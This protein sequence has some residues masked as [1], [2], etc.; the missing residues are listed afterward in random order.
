M[1]SNE[2][3]SPGSRTNQTSFGLLDDQA[4]QDLSLE[5]LNKIRDKPPIPL[6][7]IN[8]RILQER[9]FN[10]DKSLNFNPNENPDQTQ[11]SVH[12]NESDL[13][14]LEYD[15]TLDVDDDDDDED[16]ENLKKNDFKDMSR[17]FAHSFTKADFTNVSPDNMDKSVNKTLSNKSSDK[18]NNDLLLQ[19]CGRTPWPTRPTRPNT[20]A[21]MAEHLG[22]LGRTPWPTRPNTLADMAEYPGRLGRPHR[23][24]L[25]A[26]PGRQNGRGRAGRPSGVTILLE[27]LYINESSGILRNSGDFENFK[28]DNSNESRRINYDRMD[29][30]NSRT[31]NN[32][33]NFS[34]DKD[35]SKDREINLI[36]DTLDQY[37]KKL[38]SE[39]DTSLSNDL[40]NKLS[41]SFNLTGI[42]DTTACLKQMS[43]PKEDNHE[44]KNDSTLNFSSSLSD[45]MEQLIQQ[46]VERV[47]R[48]GQAHLLNNYNEDYLNLISKPN[49]EI[50]YSTST[51]GPDP[52]NASFNFT[53]DIP[54]TP[55]KTFNQTLE[56]QEE[57]KIIEEV[58]SKKTPN[59][60]DDSIQNSEEAVPVSS[61]NPFDNPFDS[62]LGN[63]GLNKNQEPSFS[64]FKQA[65]DFLDQLN[66]DEQLNRKEF[67]DNELTLINQTSDN[68]SDDS[69][70]SKWWKKPAQVQPNN[71]EV[72]NMSNES[73]KK[74]VK[75]EEFFMGKSEMPSYLADKNSDVLLSDVSRI[76]KNTNVEQKDQQEPTTPQNYDDITFSHNQG[77]TLSSSNFSFTLN[78]SDTG[79]FILPKNTTN[80]KSVEKP[81]QESKLK[82]LDKINEELDKVQN[83]LA[84]RHQISEP[85]MSSS[86]SQ[87]NRKSMIQI[88]E[89]ISTIN[90]SDISSQKAPRHKEN[91]SNKESKKSSGSLTSTPS[92]M[93]KSISESSNLSRL[94]GTSLME[95]FY[96]SENQD[97]F[98]SSI[99]E[100]N[101]STLPVNHRH[102]NSK[103]VKK[104]KNAEIQ[105]AHEENRQSISNVSSTSSTSSDPTN[106]LSGQFNVINNLAAAMINSSTNSN[107]PANGLVPVAFIPLNSFIPCVQKFY[108]DMQTTQGFINKTNVSS[109]VSTNSLNQA[110]NTKLFGDTMFTNSTTS[111]ASLNYG[112]FELP[113]IEFDR[114]SID[115][116]QIAEGCSQTL[117]IHGK[118]MNTN[119]INKTPGS[120]FQIE[121]VDSSDWT[122]DCF[123]I[124]WEKTG[125]KSEEEKS[126]NRISL[127]KKKFNESTLKSKFR[128]TLSINA[129]RNFDHDVNTR[130]NFDLMANLFEFFIK[131]D[132]TD[133]NFYKDFIS[134]LDSN[135]LD[136]V[137]PLQI[138]TSL[139]IY[140]FFNSAE[141]QTQNT[142]LKKYLLNR[143]DVEFV[144]GYARLRSSASQNCIDFELC[145]EMAESVK[146]DS[147]NEDKD[148]TL[149]SV[150]ELNGSKNLMVLEQ[151]IF[152][153]NAGNIDIEVE[154]YLT[155]NEHHVLSVKFRD[156][157]LKLDDSLLYLQSKLRQRQLAKIMAAKIS[158]Q[159]S[160][161]E[162]R[163]PNVKLVVKIKPNGFKFE[164]PINLK[165]VKKIFEA[166]KNIEKKSLKLSSSRPILFFGKSLNSSQKHGQNLDATCGL[167]DEFLLAN[168]NTFRIKVQLTLT[169]PSY[170]CFKFSTEMIQASTQLND[171]MTALT[172]ILEPSENFKLKIKFHPVTNSDCQI[173]NGILKMTAAGF[174]QKFNVY[175][176]A[177]NFQSVLE[178]DS[179]LK[180]I[181]FDQKDTLGQQLIHRNIKNFNYSIDLMQTISTSSRSV[182]R[183]ILRLKNKSSFKLIAY[184]CV[185]NARTDMEI[186]FEQSLKNNEIVYDL[187]SDSKGFVNKLR[188]LTSKDSQF[189][190]NGELKWIEVKPDEVF[191]LNLE[192]LG[193]KLDSKKPKLFNLED[194]KLCILWI[195]YDI[196]AYCTQLVQSANSTNRQWSNFIDL[197]LA[198]LMYNNNFFSSQ[199]NI[200]GSSLNINDSSAKL[201]RLSS[202]SAMSFQDESS[203]SNS[204]I[205]AKSKFTKDDCMR[206]MRQSIKCSILNMFTESFNFDDTMDKKDDLM[207]ISLSQDEKLSGPNDAWSVSPSAIVMENLKHNEM[208]KLFLKNNLSR[209]H[210]DFD[211][212]YRS[213]YL[214]VL[215][216]NGIIEPSG[217]LELI[218]K[219]R[220]EV[221]AQLPWSGIISIW[222]NNTQKDVRVSFYSKNDDNCKIKNLTNSS[223]NSLAPSLTNSSTPYS[224]SIESGSLMSDLS[225]Y[226]IDSLS[227]TPLISASFMN[228][229][230]S[231]FLKSK[232]FSLNSTND[233]SST[234]IVR[235]GN[236]AH[237]RFPAVCVTQR[238]SIELTLTN[239][240]Q[241]YVNWKAYSTVAAF[242]RLKDDQNKLMKSNYSAFMISPNS[243]AIPPNQNQKIRIEFCPRDMYGLF[244]QYW[245]IDTRTD[246]QNL[247]QSSNPD[248]PLSY[249]CKLKLT[250]TSIP[251]EKNLEQKLVQQD[252][253]TSSR[254]AHRILRSKTNI[255][256]DTSKD[257]EKSHGTTTSSSSLVAQSMLSSTA[258][259][260]LSSSRNRVIIKDESII[261]QDTLVNQMSKC[262]V[263]IHNRE[264]IDCKISVF[265]LIEPFFCKHAE[266]SIAPKHYI[267][268]PIEFRPKA[269]GEYSDKILIKIDIY[270]VPLSCTIKAKCVQ[271]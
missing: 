29:E 35:H 219:P 179:G 209:K 220:A 260:S 234:K 160:E 39:Q 125:K 201:H 73:G 250:G 164:I 114:N 91:K 128:K 197:Y 48:I 6:K 183:K 31:Q 70:S 122:I 108:D 71:L 131:L 199:I 81:K 239:P 247:I 255:F 271:G 161:I 194:F 113:M 25:K 68:S 3:C 200:P 140:Y 251:M 77:S 151:A 215:P 166:K 80:N 64:Q 191:V 185:Y 202:A 192:I 51:V 213:N 170:N 146:M 18:T 195:E 214:N 142:S 177:F 62:S 67:A 58:S 106:S 33:I 216:S 127:I 270:E 168:S 34:M 217:M 237:V 60:F 249:T 230:S 181:T 43:L 107:N 72:T 92:K 152:L 27:P 231:T 119:S 101:D 186:V 83:G 12:L 38:P 211:V 56:P 21:D 256:N 102:K 158:S 266:L 137:E 259:S 20:L 57:P 154:C 59:P 89:T 198:K 238:K 235:E 226:S 53:Q 253:A 135:S 5:N 180:E 136:Q 69:N 129:D 228:A 93:K 7:Q 167:T 63:F 14:Q 110:M 169:C 153:S 23:R 8:N 30:M 254:L 149:T 104:Q 41:T 115:F 84:S 88:D 17:N 66:Q 117:R 206:L 99:P 246:I 175:L 182:F 242:V 165:Y 105:T 26:A 9:N 65:D 243:G 36:K 46:S 148:K 157:E 229:P 174:N 221:F 244:N 132:T 37:P 232:S 120:F 42:D 258:N 159:S 49:R 269:I 22:R 233:D 224:N 204:S 248:T 264:S 150:N 227:L 24:R 144:L 162:P 109:N 268:I 85:L 134:Q 86:I 196:N 95:K 61:S 16:K 145:E 240:T 133:L 100:R 126:S 139:Y 40:T 257:V 121:L 171:S 15:F 236:D 111:L 87:A 123:E 203:L 267:K 19:F 188:L 138:K 96:K 2:F 76:D 265:T 32:T 222:C 47:K 50:R 103:M 173:V 52:K 176:V 55:S 116:G 189:S 1:D 225:Q 143:I 75:V 210:L 178:I 212:K 98:I 90:S 10:H 54:L 172:L 11:E 252:D 223:L 193:Q 141:N 147:F 74:Q 78:S 184:P 97:S 218:V 118:L 163:A 190:S 44:T 124:N 112:K 130:V 82:N 13:K 4:M 28:L 155:L 207:Q 261:F 94:T 262:F 156:Y 205:I 187:G 241:N 263:T 208:T 45:R 245:E 79:E